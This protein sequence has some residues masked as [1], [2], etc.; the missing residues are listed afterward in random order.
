VKAEEALFCTVQT[1]WLGYLRRDYVK[2]GD[3]VLEKGRNVENLEDK[4]GSL[5][6]KIFVVSRKRGLSNVDRPIT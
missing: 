3:G 2:H 6:E 1:N 5:C 4:V